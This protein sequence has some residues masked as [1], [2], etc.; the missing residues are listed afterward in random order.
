[1][2]PGDIASA[3]GKMRWKKLF[4]G[5]GLWFALL[6]AVEIV[7]ALIHP[8]NYIFQFN[9]PRFFGLLIIALVV[10][11]FQ[12]WFE[13]LFFRSYLMRGLGLLTHFRWIPLVLTTAG[14]GLLHFSNPEVKEFGFWGVMPFYIGFGLFAGLIVI[15]DDGIEL[16]FGIHA[17]NNIYQTVLVTFQSSVLQTPALFKMKKVDILLMNAGFFIM[18]IVF[19]IIM[20]R[21]YKWKDFGK[22]FR[23]IPFEKKN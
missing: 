8:G 18:V 10:I 1:M 20:A 11:P 6:I 14:F 15:L 12:T 4:A 23:V 2:K 5:A 19:L 3:A 17:A 16:S 13:E 22:I 9:A 7:A 21:V